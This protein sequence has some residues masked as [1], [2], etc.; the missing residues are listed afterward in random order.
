MKRILAFLFVASAVCFG[1]EASSQAEDSTGAWRW[2]NFGI[3]AAGLLYL[4][5]KNL[6]PY[7]RARTES[8]RKDIEEAQKLK[9]EADQ[10]AAEIDK[11]VSGLSAEIAAF[12]AQ[13]IEEMDREG[14]R[15]RQEAATHVRKI[16]DQAQVE[17]ESAAKAAR[18]ELRLYAA[19]L[20]LD[21][22]AQRVR[23]RLDA[24]SEGVLVGN[25]IADLKKQESN[26]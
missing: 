18:R 7:F 19:D 12:R 13:S 6:P 2:I 21:L 20:A 17:I 23:G 10:K 9:R 24:S 25:F 26:N 14:E 15:I 3:L 5:I 8:I 11:R 16:G 4:L 1:Q 22:A